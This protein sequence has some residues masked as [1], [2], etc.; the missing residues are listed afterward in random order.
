MP[1][2][3]NNLLVFPGVVRGA[4]DTRIENVTKEYKIAAAEALAAY[5]E[6][7][8]VDRLLPSPLDKSVPWVVAQAM[9]M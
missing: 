8:M 4:L 3:I 2:Q 1:N 7:P 6:C 9:L 5:I